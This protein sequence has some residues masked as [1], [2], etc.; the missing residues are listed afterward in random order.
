MIGLL[1]SLIPIIVVFIEHAE[2]AEERVANGAEGFGFLLVLEADLEL[3]VVDGRG[4][5][6]R[7]GVQNDR[8]LLVGGRGY[9][10]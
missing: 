2:D 1:D 3:D 5:P 7:G 4:V 8:L 10:R 9:L 6:L